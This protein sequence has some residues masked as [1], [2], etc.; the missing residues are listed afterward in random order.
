MLVRGATV[1]NTNA[2]RVLTLLDKTKGAPFGS[3]TQTDDGGNAHYN[4]LLFSAQH[5]FS[6]NFT[7]LVNYTFSHCL[8]DGDFNN[9]LTGATYQS[10]NDRRGDRANC[11]FDHRHIFNSSVIATT[12]RFGSRWTQIIAS[13]WEV[14]GILT[15]QSG[16]FWNVTTGRDASLTAVGLD[17][18]NVTGDWHIAN[19]T[20]T[21]WF[22]PA[23][24]QANG[25][26]MF[27]NAGR[28]LILGPKVVNLDMGLMRQVPVRESWRLEFRAE[29]FN[30]LN[31]ANMN[32]TSTN[33]LHTALNDPKFGSIT[34]AA[35]P[36]ILQ[37]ALKVLF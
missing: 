21:Q 31:H 10:P 22:N 35:D 24:F 18:P 29:A 11:S 7:S 19:P 15:A 33:Q 20:F 9:D 5:R 30:V 34:G 2:R 14:S 6:H 36:R 16:G 23:A 12:P 28:N 27:G 3:I 1:A 37:F 8:S 17:R 13:H 25:P 4:G 26:G 32:M